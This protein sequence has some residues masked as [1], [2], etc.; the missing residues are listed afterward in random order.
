MT[1]TGVVVHRLDKLTQTPGSFDII[2]DKVTGTYPGLTTQI[3]SLCRRMLTEKMSSLFS[4]TIK[5]A[6]CAI[7]YGWLTFT[8]CWPE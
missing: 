6:F 2:D 4:I 5:Q 7:L 1:T 8:K 3:D